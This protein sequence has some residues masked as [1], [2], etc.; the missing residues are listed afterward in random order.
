MADSINSLSDI[1]FSQS[2]MISILVFLMTSVAFG[3]GVVFG[4]MWEKINTLSAS[5]QPAIPPLST[6]VD[7]H[8]DKVPPRMIKQE[9]LDTALLNEKVNV[10]DR[11][12]Q[13]KSRVMRYPTV[14][15][16]TEQANKRAMDEQ[17]NGILTQHRREQESEVFPT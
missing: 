1:V 11:A 16:I 15:E 17:I 12:S 14:R 4:R 10:L 8:V 6:H 5:Y 9:P 3:L 7:K 2:N 13:P